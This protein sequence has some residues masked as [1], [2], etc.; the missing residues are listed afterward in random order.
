MHAFILVCGGAVA[1]VNGEVLFQNYEQNK[2]GLTDPNIYLYTLLEWIGATAAT[3]FLVSVVHVTAGSSLMQSVDSSDL[4][5]LPPSLPP[6]HR[7]SS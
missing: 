4:P 2:P 7:P 5:S 6:S 3:F 1:Y